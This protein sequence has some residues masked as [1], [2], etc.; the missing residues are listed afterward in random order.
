[1]YL[2]FSIKTLFFKNISFESFF[3]STKVFEAKDIRHTYILT[4]KIFIE[5]LQFLN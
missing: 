3:T 5:G 2:I 4:K 1:M